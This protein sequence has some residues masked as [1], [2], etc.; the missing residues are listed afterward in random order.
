MPSLSDPAFL[1]DRYAF[2][3]TLH[4]G[5][6]VVWDDGA[7]TFLATTHDAVIEGFRSTKL[8]S[9]RVGTLSRAWS[10]DVKREMRPLTDSL[11]LWMLY[12]DPPDHTRLR[13]IMTR[14]FTP[15]IVESMRPRVQALVDE[16]LDAAVARGGA[17]DVIA[18]LAFPL[19]ATVIL[20]MLGIPRADR[21]RFK[22]WSNDIARM[23][24]GVTFVESTAARAN[25]A[26]LEM[27]EYFGPL[28]RARRASPQDDLISALLA[29]TERHDVLSDDELVANCVMLMFGGHETT[30]NLIGNGVLALLAHPQELARWRTDPTL[31]PAAVDELLR[32]DAPVQIMRRT[33]L[34]PMTLAG[35]DVPE[36]A[37]VTLLI[38]AA[39]RDARAFPEPDRLDLGRK[40]RH[41]GFGFGAHFCVGAALARLEGDVA[42]GT[43]IRRFPALRLASVEPPRWHPSPVLRA[44][45]SLPVRTS[46]A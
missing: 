46:D 32:Y 31:G 25:R 40:P 14:A 38:G 37:F 42:I 45:A 24:G 20:E 23:I 17:L 6:P 22:A 28:F 10:D 16:L 13:A 5:P 7:R 1:D 39:N 2:Y 15:R 4:E 8:S 18:D 27:R 41:T 19:P 43:L 34:E 9:R 44:L 12:Q 33:A 3:R 11:S 29:A 35:T 36:G 26:V 21:D 30:T